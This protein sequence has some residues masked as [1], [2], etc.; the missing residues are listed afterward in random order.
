MS[1]LDS[2]RESWEP[3]PKPILEQCQYT[4]SRQKA[5]AD[6]LATGPLDR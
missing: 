3:A 1:L 5:S 6:S 2:I 4:H